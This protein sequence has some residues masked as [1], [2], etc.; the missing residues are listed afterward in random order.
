[1]CF[2]YWEV[3]GER[4]REVRTLIGVK[5]A[6]VKNVELYLQAEIYRRFGVTHCLHILETKPNLEYRT[7]HHHSDRP[8][9]TYSM[10]QSPS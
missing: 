7:S 10:E 8:L 1:M 9:L 4:E 2:F 6:V 5:I 3:G